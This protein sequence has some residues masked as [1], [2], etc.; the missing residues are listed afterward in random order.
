MEFGQTG[1]A[2][3][4]ENIRLLVVYLT[5]EVP[6]EVSF[7]KLYLAFTQMESEAPL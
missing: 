2:L 6:N 7:K 3:S 5:Q 4:D 1:R